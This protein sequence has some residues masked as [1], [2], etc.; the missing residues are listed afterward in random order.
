MNKQ[1]TPKER[2]R[3]KTRPRTPEDRKN[4]KRAR[5]RF[6]HSAYN[7]RPVFLGEYA[8]TSIHSHIQDTVCIKCKMRTG[9]GAVNYEDRRWRCF[10]CRTWN[11][12]TAREL[13]MIK[14]GIYIYDDE[15]LQEMF[16]KSAKHREYIEKA[17]RRPKRKRNPMAYQRERTRI[18][19]EYSTGT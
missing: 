4:S 13:R 10:R 16:T 3:Q 2:H 11:D 12:F 17:S 15:K 6:R 9:P 18:S 8:N 1:P 14:Y 5:E 19:E 7:T